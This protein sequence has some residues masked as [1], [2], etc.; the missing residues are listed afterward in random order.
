[1]NEIQAWKGQVKAKFTFVSA[2][3]KLKSNLKGTIKRRQ[4]VEE[5]ATKERKEKIV[6]L[7]M[8]I[9]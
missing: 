7:G 4:C 5:K 8:R 3:D 2:Y 9:W 6:E 1:L